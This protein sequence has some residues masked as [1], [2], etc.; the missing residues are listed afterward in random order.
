[1]LNN[2]CMLVAKQLTAN[3]I[4]FFLFVLIQLLL[5]LLLEWDYIR[6]D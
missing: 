2:L 1:M 6:L 4:V 3:T 5:A